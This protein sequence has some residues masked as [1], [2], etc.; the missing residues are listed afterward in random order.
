MLG[1]TLPTSPAR[2][3]TIV[4]SGLVRARLSRSKERVWSNCTE[5]FVISCPRNPWRVNWFIYRSDVFWL[6]A[7]GA[8]ESGVRE[9]TQQQPNLQRDQLDAS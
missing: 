2:L 7:K 4:A 9:T 5:C 8:R 6:P 3:T 1:G